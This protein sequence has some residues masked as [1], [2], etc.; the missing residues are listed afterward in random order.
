MSAMLKGANVAN[1]VWT[2]PNFQTTDAEDGNELPPYHH[3]WAC[4]D[5][6]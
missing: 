5:L 6:G 4:N 3:R 1:T 2:T